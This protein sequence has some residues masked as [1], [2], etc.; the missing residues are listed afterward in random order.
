MVV[1]GGLTDYSWYGAV[2]LGRPCDRVSPLCPT[3]TGYGY[4]LCPT[5]ILLP[6]PAIAYERLEP[7]PVPSTCESAIAYA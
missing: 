4:R 3:R 5:R 6:K 7:M 1:P 2:P